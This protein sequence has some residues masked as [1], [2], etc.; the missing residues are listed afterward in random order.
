MLDTGSILLMRG[1]C[2]PGVEAYVESMPPI[3]LVVDD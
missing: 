3:Q 2:T 1:V